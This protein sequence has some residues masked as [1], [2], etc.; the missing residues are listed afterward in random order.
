M[1]ATPNTTVR[2][3]ILPVGYPNEDEFLAMTDEDQ[4]R[5]VSADWAWAHEQDY[6]V[7]YEYYKSNSVAIVAQRVVGASDDV[8]TLRA[9][10]ANELG[11]HPE[12]I[13]VI[14]IEPGSGGQLWRT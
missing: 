14:D 3:S 5:L 11:V 13:V 12:Q 10:V 9:Q 6:A 2:Q 1:S 4:W 8:V 7:W